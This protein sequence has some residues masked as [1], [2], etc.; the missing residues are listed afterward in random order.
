LLPGEVAAPNTLTGKTTA[1][2]TPVSL[3]AGGN[4]DVTV[5]A[6]D[7]DWN[8]VNSSDT[9]SLS[10]SD[11]LAFLPLNMAMS[12]GTVTFSGLNAI[13]FSTE[14]SQTI[15]AMDAAPGSTIPTA[16]SAPVTVGP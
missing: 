16:T 10:S 7:D 11:E 13:G 15:T 5:N 9:I 2:P 4:E 1:T 3:G 12:G 14:G 6:V 8:I